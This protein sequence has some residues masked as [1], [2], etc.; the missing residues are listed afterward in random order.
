MSDSGHYEFSVDKI[1]V[2]LFIFTGL[3]VGWGYF[4][5]YIG[6]SKLPLWGGLIGCAVVKA[7]LIAAY[8]MHFKFEGWIVKGLILPTPFLILVIFGYINKDISR[9]E[10]LD[11]PIGSMYDETS[12]QVHDYMSH[13]SER[14]GAGF[15]E[16][17]HDDGDDHSGH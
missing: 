3:E 8:F 9:N 10:K 15:D 12:G 5:D 14:P 13:T 4:G 16:V 17:A 7:F 6:M 1:F 11:H 2:W